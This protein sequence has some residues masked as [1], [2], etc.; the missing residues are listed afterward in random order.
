M[1]QSGP[2]IRFV[3]GALQPQP[4]DAERTSARFESLSVSGHTRNYGFSEANT[5]FRLN[6]FTLDPLWERRDIRQFRQPRIG[7][8]TGRQIEAASFI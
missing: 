3:G 2:W 8:D 7:P 1:T 4:V 5:Y 6:D